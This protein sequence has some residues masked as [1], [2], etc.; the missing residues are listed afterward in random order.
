MH[1]KKTFLASSLLL[2]AGCS[3]TTPTVES[4]TTYWIY[5]IK[6]S[7]S[8]ADV[9]TAVKEAVQTQMTSVSIS[10]NLPPATVPDQ[11]GKFQ[12]SNAL[13]NSNLGQ[14]LAYNGASIE[15]PTCDGAIMIGSSQHNGM[16]S[17]GEQSQVNICLWQYKDGYH[18]DIISK[19]T[20]TSGGFDA[21]SLAKNLVESV[22]G[23]GSQFIPTRVNNIVN[24]LNA[25]GMQVSLVEKYP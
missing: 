3:S 22:M 17:A 14:L 20:K 12:M 11:P 9:E 16:A 15:M 1:L 8:L 23:D 2:L 13:G 25:A 7:Q 19:F 24:K 5:D 6:A 10:R 18:L 4:T 21:R